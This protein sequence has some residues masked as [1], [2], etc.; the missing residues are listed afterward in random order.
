MSKVTS[1]DLLSYATFR[2]RAQDESL[3]EYEKIGFPDTY[4]K[5]YG[6]TIF[7]DICA[8]LPNLAEPKQTV[9]DIGPGCSDLPRLMIE[10]CRQQEHRL[11]LID[12]PEMLDQLP[13]APFIKK[14]P[15]QYPKECPQLFEEYGGKVDV[16][17][18]YSVLQIAF[19]EGILYPFIDQTLTLL[20]DG[21][22]WLMGDIP[23][24]SMRKRFFSSPNGV[25]FHKQFMQT[26]DAPDVRFNVPEIG[27]IDDAVLMGLLLRCRS[28][29]FDSYLLPQPEGLPMANRREDLL[30]LKP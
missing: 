7:A 4:R 26:T 15:G 11:I 13:D 8:K 22:Q 28:A 24:I 17:I 10:L 29:G 19:A 2:K 1:E 27:Q 25:R 30:V 3:S 6:E 20:A 18:A 5:G 16:A 14:M 9:L 23:N 12:A 21:A